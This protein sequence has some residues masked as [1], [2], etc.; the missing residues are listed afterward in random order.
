[1]KNIGIVAKT[2]SPMAAEGVRALTAWLGKRGMEYMIDAESA[3]VAGM[4][5]GLTKVDLIGKADLI[6]V[7]GGDGT[8]LSVARMMEKRAIPI[9]GVNLGSLGFLAEFTYE[10]MFPALERVLSGDYTYEDRIMLDVAISRE[11]KRVAFY[12]V[13]NDLVINRGALARMV[14][15]Q[16]AVDGRFVNEYTADGLIIS[17]PTGSTAYSLAAGG[18]IVYPSLN[19]IIISPIC[20]HTLSNRPIVIPDSVEIEISIA[21]GHSGEAVATLDGQVGFQLNYRDRLIAKRSKEVTRVIQSPF[22]DYYQ[23]LR[24]KLK[25]GEAIRH[26]ENETV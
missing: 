19:A 13:L 18:P 17:T 11:G 6:V 22:K 20:P 9:L 10:E 16:V 3:E 15:V 24:G 5:S 14:D 1:M 12:T 25:W 26:G 23:L 4:K 7:M 8:F 21:S 2:K